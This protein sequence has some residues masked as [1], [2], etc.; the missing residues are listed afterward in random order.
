M[1]LVHFEPL[2]VPAVSESDSMATY[3]DC[4]QLQAEYISHH[5]Y[6]SFLHHTTLK[7]SHACALPQ[8]CAVLTRHCTLLVALEVMCPGICS[9]LTCTDN[10]D[11]SIIMVFMHIIIDYQR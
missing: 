11:P 8:P 6:T 3:D 7:P 9:P 10:A 2:R 1:H 4:A 5:P